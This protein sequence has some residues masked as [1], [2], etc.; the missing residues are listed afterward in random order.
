MLAEFRCLRIT[1]LQGSSKQVLIPGQISEGRD[2][3]KTGGEGS[4]LP[5]VSATANHDRQREY[6]YREKHR[7]A[8]PA[9]KSQNDS[10]CDCPSSG[11]LTF[12]AE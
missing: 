8:H 11:R 9:C 6:R 12:A 2:R 3:G 10:G 4:N 5:S 1:E 7:G